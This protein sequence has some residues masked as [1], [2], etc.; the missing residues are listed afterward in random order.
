[1]PQGPTYGELLARARRA[2]P[3]PRHPRY[4]TEELLARASGRPR[5]WFAARRGETASAEEE[6]LFDALVARRAAG[7]PLQYL[8]G[9][10]EFLGRTFRVDARALIPRHETEAIVETAR[11]AAPDAGRILDAGTGTGILAVSLALE[12][13]G[14]RVV[15]VDVSPAALFLAR[16]NARKFDVLS[17]VSL[18]GS[19]WLS[20]LA[21]RGP[22]FHLAVANPPYVPLDEAPHLQRTVSDHEP[23]AA[24][25]GGPDGLD[26]LRLLLR[27]LPPLLAPGAPF[28]FE[29]GYSQASEVSALVEASGSFSLAEVRLDPAGI[30]RTVTARR[31]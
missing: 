8:L 3:E 14:A 10:W 5:A 31:I 21:P 26:P 17:R 23:H 4:E 15:A 9:E 11:A 20:A 28:I 18:L 25:F 30:P 13:P 7:E 1:M 6:A 27:T 2:L 24:L 16:E 19:D 12:R 29:I 22:L